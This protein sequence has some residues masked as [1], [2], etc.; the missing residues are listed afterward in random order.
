MR[1]EVLV[2]GEPAQIRW[3]GDRLRYDRDGGHSVSSNYS[4]EALEPGTFSVRIGTKQYRVTLGAK[5][6]VSVNGRTLKM[7]VFDPRDLRGSGRSASGKGRQ[8][9][10]SPMPGKVIRL[11]VAAGDTVEAGQGLVVVEAMKMQNEMKSPKAG[12]V[13]EIR[14]KPEATVGAGDVLMVVE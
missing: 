13:V 7:E 2:N 5:G 3:E 1:R 10:Q 9:I 12:K 4:I 8:E 14:T 11:L 6:E